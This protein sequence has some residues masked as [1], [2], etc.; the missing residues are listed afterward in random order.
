LSFHPAVQVSGSGFACSH[1][2][3]LNYDG[4]RVVSESL[5]RA[6]KQNKIKSPG[7]EAKKNNH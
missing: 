4:S 2:L 1:G 3:I 5:V 6:G 7:S